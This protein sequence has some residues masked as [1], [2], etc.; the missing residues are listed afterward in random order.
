MFP[1]V[2][3]HLGYF[4]SSCNVR[5]NI[6]I[7]SAYNSAVETLILHTN[8]LIL[9]FLIL[10][11]QIPQETIVTNLS[12][13]NPN[14]HDYAQL[15]SADSAHMEGE[16]QSKRYIPT[17][18]HAKCAYVMNVSLILI[19]FSRLPWVVLFILRSYG[20]FTYVCTLYKVLIR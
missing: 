9:R 12:L 15:S 18:Q 19:L 2:C 16:S 3:Y 13:S 5:V 7:L 10:S 6:I 20:S 14:I 1:L 4:S 11:A 17:L 8:A